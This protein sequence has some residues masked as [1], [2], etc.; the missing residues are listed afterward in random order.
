MPDPSV[1][2]P[3]LLDSA[4][5]EAPSA[6]RNRGPI[7]DALRPR[8]PPSGS[9]LEI[10]SGTGEHVTHF[11]QALPTLLWQP[12]DPSPECRASIDAWAA[13][14]PNVLPALALDAAAPA[15][16]IR[17]A[18][19]ILCINMIH[20]APWSAAQG[21]FHGAARILTAGGLLALYGA[22]RRS[23]APL[24]PGN[25]DFD[26]DLRSR[27]PAWGLRELDLVADLA[28]TVGFGR[29]EVV[30]MPADNLLVAFRRV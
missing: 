26:I 15:W 13:N 4:R 20:I 3:S 6:A 21:L 23:P 10:A 19:A 12:S 30:D 18:D 11:A 22:F 29:P 2:D 5:L 17:H 25:I 9:V 16:P 27:N 7:L 24:T 1:P 8:L 28:G 14:L